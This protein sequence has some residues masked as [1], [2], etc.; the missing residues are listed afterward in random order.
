MEEQDSIEFIYQ[1]IKEKVDLAFEDIEHIETKAG[2]LIGFNG[3]IISLALNIVERVYSPLFIASIL[4]FLFALLLNFMSF[5]TKKYRRDPNPRALME[6]YWNSP[7]R[8]IVEKLIANLAECHKH[9]EDIISPAARW[10]NYS[11]FLTSAGLTFL[12][13]SA[14]KN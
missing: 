3:V 1:T 12:I 14:M 10:L 11:M 7:K 4:F 2:I 13:A 5:R 9:N 8:E 6:R